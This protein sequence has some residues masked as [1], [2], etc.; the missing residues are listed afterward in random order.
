[1]F[2]QFEMVARTPKDRTQARTRW[3]EPALDAEYG[4]DGL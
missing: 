4:E 1:L 3:S 2:E